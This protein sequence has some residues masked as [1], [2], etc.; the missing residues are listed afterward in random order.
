M[1]EPF[2]IIKIEDLAKKHKI[3]RILIIL[4]FNAHLI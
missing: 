3:A 1:C 2:F 4:H